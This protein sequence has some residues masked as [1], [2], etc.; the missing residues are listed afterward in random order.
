MFQL[1]IFSEH[2]HEQ[3]CCRTNRVGLSR[4][5]DAATDWMPVWEDDLLPGEC[6]L[7][8]RVDRECL[9]LENVATDHLLTS[10]GENLSECTVLPIPCRLKLG[11]TWVEFSHS[12]ESRTLVPIKES[13]FEDLF[14]PLDED[15]AHTGP[16]ASTVTKWLTA[17]ANL[18]RSAAG[19]AEFYNDAAEFAVETIGLDGAWILRRDDTDRDNP[20][21]IVGSHL[22]VPETG[23]SFDPSTLARLALLPTTWY[24][25]TED[26]D[27]D[28]LPN[29]IVISPVLDERQNLIGAVYGVRNLSDTNRRRGLRPLEA[30]LVQLL[31]DSVAVGIARLQHE[32][33]AARARVLLEHAFSPT[34]A[35]YIQ[36]HPE[37]LL[38]QERE[39]TLMFADL[40]GYSALAETL[41]LTDCY[42]LLSDVME[43]LTQVVV[44]HH[45]IVVDY[46]GDGLLALWNA[47]LKQP[48]HADLACDAALQMFE[49]LE[50]VATQWNDQLE[51]PLELGIGIHSGPACVGNAGT[52]SRLKYGP[53]GNTVNVTSRVQSASKQLELPLVITE[54]TQAKLSDR[55]FT[56]RVCTAKLPGLEQ[57]AELFTAY[58][59]SK[60]AKLKARLDEYARALTLFENGELEAA[61]TLLADLAIDGAATPARFLADHTATQKNRNMGRRAVDKYTAQNGPIIEILSK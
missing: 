33:E 52:R 41:P 6:P 1:A 16:A 12:E 11:E 50:V 26:S 34:V 29:A 31:A 59:A 43:A 14:A 8:V 51:K 22:S 61:E 36:R 5:D 54:A 55:F 60:A 21:Q 7:V 2:R 56:L 40:R 45:G 58:P 35:E 20:W 13:G 53:R 37:S 44:R 30:R 25:Q 3:F 10:D 42:D 19:S 39:V 24:Q 4:S 28:K 32:T 57:P 9:V 46:Y 47:P 17:T 48:N 23:I 15:V 27:L 38:G 49:A 18:H